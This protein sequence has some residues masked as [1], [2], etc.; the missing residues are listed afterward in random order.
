MEEFIMYTVE[1]ISDGCFNV[2]DGSNSVE[3]FDNYIDAAVRCT[4]LK[5]GISLER[6]ECVK[7][8]EQ[9]YLIDY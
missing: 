3:S 6:Y 8:H 1:K 7:D 5:T 4:E 2:M 9:D